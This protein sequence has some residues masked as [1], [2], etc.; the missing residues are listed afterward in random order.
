MSTVTINI[1]DE[2]AGGKVTNE[3]KVSFKDNLTTV[4]D[5][6][7]ARVHAEVESYNKRMPEYFKG[8]VQPKDAETTLNGF[9]VKEKRKV[10][11]EKQILTALD[12]FNK[13]GY[14]VLIDNIQAEN[15]EQMVVINANT[16]ISFVKLTP[17]VG[18]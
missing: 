13:N 2:T 8:L 17:L 7:K 12:A 15:L 9:R 6:I 14:F 5:I 10:D 18:G 1:K 16:S 4:Q 11:A 3:L